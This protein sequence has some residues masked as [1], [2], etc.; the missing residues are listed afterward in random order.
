MP[1]LWLPNESR[2]AVFDPDTEQVRVIGWRP[3]PAGVSAVELVPG[4]HV[5]VDHASPSTLTELAVP[6]DVRRRTIHPTVLDLVA[7][8]LGDEATDV[9]ASLPSRPTRLQTY[10]RHID[11]VR[12]LDDRYHR[13]ARLVLAA[14]LGD[15][16]ALSEAA[17]GAALLEAALAAVDVHGPSAVDLARRGLGVLTTADLGGGR[18]DPKGDARLESLVRTVAG[19]VEQPDVWDSVSRVLDQLRVRRRPPA[20]AAPAVRFAEESA[21]NFQVAASKASYAADRMERP[22]RPVEVDGDV[23]G[24]AWLD[25]GNN[26]RVTAGAHAAGTWARVFRR[27]DRLLL[28]LAPMREV[29]G[30]QLDGLV[31]IPPVDGPD[32]LV[33]DL[34]TDPARPRRSPTHDLV[35]QA[36]LTGRRAARLSRLGDPSAAAVWADCARQWDVLGDTQRANL[37]RRQDAGSARGRWGRVPPLL[38]DELDG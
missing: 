19:H 16:A 25:D 2:M 17:R 15:D 14:D 32:A 20:A 18:Y 29:E 21:A 27:H 31:V 3:G 1:E 6:V 9:L 28:G 38:A 24:W 5:V 10:D 4:L 8:L 7:Q 37:A 13:F 34:V 35:R 36:V 26:V 23:R 30:G 11:D 33:V 22:G 12:F